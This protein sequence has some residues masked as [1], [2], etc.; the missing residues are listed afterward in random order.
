MKD[1]FLEKVKNKEN[2]LLNL[3]NGI[4]IE[5]TFDNDLEAYRGYAKEINVKLGI[6]TIKTLYQIFNKEYGEMEFI[7]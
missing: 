1:K 4:T 3:K 5:L 2:L 7:L 6:W